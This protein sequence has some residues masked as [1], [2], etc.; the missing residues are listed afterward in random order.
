[1]AVVPSTGFLHRLVICLPLVVKR[2]SALD[3]QPVA[4]PFPMMSDRQDF[5]RLVL[6]VVDDC[7]GVPLEN[8]AVLPSSSVLQASG[9]FAI[10]S[11]AS[12]TSVR[13]PSAAERLRSRY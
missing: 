1:M 7:E 3:G 9:A 2:L 10:R 4:G 12:M 13:K 5:Y 6:H 8:L 11:I